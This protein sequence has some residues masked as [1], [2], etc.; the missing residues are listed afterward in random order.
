M[1]T[2]LL[3]HIIVIALRQ[4]RKSHV[5]LDACNIT[6]IALVK[7]SY[8]TLKFQKQSI[9]LNSIPLEEISTLV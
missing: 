5:V 2:K 9:L 8:K 7:N 6:C 4:D 1:F 3:P